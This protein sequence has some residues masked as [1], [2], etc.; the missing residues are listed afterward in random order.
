MGNLTFSG[1]QGTAVVIPVSSF[2]VVK[3]RGVGYTVQ[4][5][6]TIKL[7]VLT[8]G[9]LLKIAAAAG[10]AGASTALALSA[11]RSNKREEREETVEV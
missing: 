8:E 11:G 9:S 4:L 2:A 1:A 5:S 3:Y 6:P 7:P 10:A